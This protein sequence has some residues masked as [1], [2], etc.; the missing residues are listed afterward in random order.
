MIGLEN[1]EKYKF[2]DV[3]GFEGIIQINLNEEVKA[4]G[5]W[6]R[7]SKTSF[8]LD[9]K[10]VRVYINRNGYKEVG[11]FR[12][13]KAK[14][15]MIHRLLAMVFIP[16]KK[17]YPLVRHLNDNKL[18]NRIENLKW[19]TKKDNAQDAIRNGTFAYSHRNHTVHIRSILVLDTQTGIFY[20]SIKDAAIAKNIK[21]RTLAAKLKGDY[22]NN[23]GLIYA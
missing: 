18:D 8:Y 22:K 15:L 3:P 17:N 10:K 11:V 6:T 21:K 19:G 14:K 12:S 7:N 20:D 4:L 23:T 9:E 2:F 16:N 13:G 5:R 1:I